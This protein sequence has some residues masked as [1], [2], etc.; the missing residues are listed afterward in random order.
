[1]LRSCPRSNLR[2]PQNTHVPGCTHPSFWNQQPAGVSSLL[3]KWGSDRDSKDYR[4]TGLWARPCKA[5]IGLGKKLIKSVFLLAKSEEFQKG[6][7]PAASVPGIQA[8]AGIPQHQDLPQG[9]ELDLSYSPAQLPQLM[10]EVP[11]KE[12]PLQTRLARMSLKPKPRRIRGLPQ[13]P[14]IQVA[15]WG[16]R[17]LR[18]YPDFP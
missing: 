6:P 12:E 10:G 16:T 14:E 5:Q 7:G 4:N 11:L 3:D 1:M 8:S 15:L 9:C 17:G 13:S 2:C 18:V